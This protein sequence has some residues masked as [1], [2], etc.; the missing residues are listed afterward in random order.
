MDSSYALKG[1]NPIWLI[2]I[3]TVLQKRV[4]FWKTTGADPGFLER[5]VHKD[6]GVCVCVGG[7]LADFISFF[8]NMP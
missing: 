5:G 8:L 6:K 7:S 2:W 4:S 3:F 1:V